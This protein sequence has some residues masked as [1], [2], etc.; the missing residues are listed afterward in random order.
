LEACT[1]PNC[2]LAPIALN[3][4]PPKLYGTEV[5][6]GCEYPLHGKDAVNA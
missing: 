1:N 2:F 6:Q 3:H 5:W 4:T